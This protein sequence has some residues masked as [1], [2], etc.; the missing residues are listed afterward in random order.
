MQRQITQDIKNKYGNKVVTNQPNATT[1]AVPSQSKASSQNNTSSAYSAL[2]A[3]TNSA[4]ESINSIS[5]PVA[6][7]G[8]LSVDIL[9]AGNAAD[10]GFVLYPNMSNTN[11]IQ[12]VYSKH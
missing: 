9:G 5:V 11:Q 6:P 2:V 12:G 7:L 8:T 3:A 10:G 4:M 1:K